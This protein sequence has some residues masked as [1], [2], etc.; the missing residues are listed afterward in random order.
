M[1]SNWR[2][3]F[4]ILTN[5]MELAL[6]C[7]KIWDDYYQ[8]I[9]PSIPGPSKRLFRINPTIPGNTLPALDDVHRMAELRSHVRM[10]P[11]IGTNI[12]EVAQHLVASSFYFDLDS[13]EEGLLD[14]CKVQGTSLLNSPIPKAQILQLTVS[15]THH[16][17]LGKVS[18]RFLAQTEELR[19]F[20]EYLTQRAITEGP[21]SLTI[22]SSP[23]AHK[24]PP[25]AKVPLFDMV[26][27]M[28]MGTLLPQEISFNMKWVVTTIQMELQFG[29]K[30][31]ES[32]LISGFPRSFS[33]SDSSHNNQQPTRGT[34]HQH[35][36]RSPP[37]SE[38]N[39]FLLRNRDTVDWKP[40]Q[41]LDSYP[42]IDLGHYEDRTRTLGGRRQTDS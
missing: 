33:P 38:N 40:P 9:A 27:A 22:Q 4:Q 37:A 35:R 30:N 12:V 10:Y 24:L 21:L 25:L 20:G 13:I 15:N 36:H 7:D 5:N 17:L 34:Q 11:A 8:V 39:S 2:H 28:R 41:I 3:L 26:Q 42:H 31:N 32:Y 23:P 1:L 16:P 29:D 6:D 14:R 19:H 18:C